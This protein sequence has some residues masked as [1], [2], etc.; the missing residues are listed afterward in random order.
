MSTYVIVG[1]RK[2]YL[3]I[4]GDRTVYHSLENSSLGDVGIQGT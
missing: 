1:G 3:L 2:L 4:M